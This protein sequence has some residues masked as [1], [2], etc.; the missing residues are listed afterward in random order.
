MGGQQISLPNIKSFFDTSDAVVHLDIKDADGKMKALLF[1]LPIEEG[2]ARFV[3]KPK[4]PDRPKAGVES[5]LTIQKRSGF[6]KSYPR[7][8]GFQMFPGDLNFPVIDLQRDA[9]AQA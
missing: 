9:P 7:Y 3:A 5:V 6:P 2:L 1:S 4:D 8:I